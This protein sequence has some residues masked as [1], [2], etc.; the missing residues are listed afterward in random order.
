VTTRSVR[1]WT[2]RLWY[3]YA[4]ALLDAGDAEGALHWFSAAADVDD[5]EVTDAAERAEALGVAA[6]RSEQGGD[7]RS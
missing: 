1:P 3:A 6:P 7:D 4:D 2:A 5:E